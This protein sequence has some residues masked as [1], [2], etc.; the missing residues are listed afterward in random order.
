M[1]ATGRGEIEQLVSPV[2]RP[3]EQTNAMRDRFS[4][5]I[6]DPVET[7]CVAGEIPDRGRRQ[8]GL[9][10]GFRRGQRRRA[11][12]VAVAGAKARRRAARNVE[13]GWEV[14]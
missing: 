11:V 3:D 8:L 7:G 5:E 13:V 1:S 14:A 9:A 4:L 6:V 2:E 10:T 12:A